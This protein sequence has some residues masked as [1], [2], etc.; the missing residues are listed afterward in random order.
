MP[1]IT[2][3]QPLSEEIQDIISYRP[4]WVIR[5]GNI[6]FLLVILLLLA[7]G[8]FIK[9][10][11]LVK[12]SVRIAAVNTPKMLTTKASGRLEKLFVSNGDLVKK[13]QLIANIQNTALHD[14]VLQLQQWIA[15]I[16]S[17]MTNGDLGI[18]SS[19]PLPLLNQLGELQPA[20]QDFQT[21]VKETMQVLPDGYYQKKRQSLA[22]D[23]QYQQLL[24]QNLDNQ[25]AVQKA[26]YDLTEKE[27]HANQQ[28]AEE[29]VI[30]PI[31]LDQIKSKLLNKEQ[32]LKQMSSQMINSDLS[33]NNKTK[34][35]LDLQKYVTDQ[36]QI[37][38]SGLLILKSKIGE[39]EQKYIITSPADGR[40][41]FTSFLQENQLLQNDQELFFVQSP[42]NKFYA[43]MKAGQNS[44]GKIKNGQQVLIRLQSYP[45]TE[46]GYISGR[47]SY[48]SSMPS[49]RDSFLIKVELPDG[50]KTNFDKD[51]LF[52]NNLLA[53]AE[54]I[55]E[56][57][58][59]IQRLFGRL[60]K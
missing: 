23:I 29:K 8:F 28:L 15:V 44:F 54:V 46:Y 59:L 20:Y 22:M 16:E 10:P 45:S 9:S 6:I 60:G 18:L 1:V 48:I 26:D 50:L 25:K 5:K 2:Q 17:S 47:I 21:T 19:Q 32:S 43:E 38:R 37:F 49:Q 58:R 36:A 51:I 34:E 27:Y 14:Q 4:G 55:T 30:A 53:S 41:E 13:D 24:Q 57:K 7:L 12:G 39:W 52:R 42:G 40:I 3:P 33:R 35:L 56:N 11:D 31:E